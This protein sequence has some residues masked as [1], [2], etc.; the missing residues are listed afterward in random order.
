MRCFLYSAVLCLSVGP[1]VA[2]AQVVD[3]QN[4]PIQIVV[5]DSTGAAVPNAEVRVDAPEAPLTDRSGQTILSL[6]SGTYDLS[7]GAQGFVT[8]KRRVVITSGGHPAVTFDLSVDTGGGPVVVAEDPR[9]QIQTTTPAPTT[10]V[11]N[12]TLTLVLPGEHPQS[13]NAADIAALPHKNVTFHN[14]HT[15]VDETYT[16]IVLADW[17][18]RL[19]IPSGDKLRGKALL[20]YVVATGSDGYKVVLSL[21]EADP[22]FHPGEVI[23]ADAMDGK[24]IAAKDGPFRLIV[25]EDKFPARC[26]RSLVSLEVKQAE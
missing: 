24:P 23:V 3:G 18:S 6:P 19:G 26:V 16:G 10:L 14:V 21:A 13:F 15:N 11:N 20:H 2:F 9:T 22:S 12:S 7:A 8:A 4:I 1:A 5:K 25:S 17:L